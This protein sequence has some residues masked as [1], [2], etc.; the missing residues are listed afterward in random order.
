[1][2]QNNTKYILYI[3]PINKSINNFKTRNKLER[4]TFSNYN[5][6]E[7]LN[8]KYRENNSNNIQFKKSM[9]KR[10]FLGRL[11]YQKRKK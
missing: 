4:N 8:V 1:M 11:R 7:S 10:L 9:D 6:Q 5:L 3:S 2:I